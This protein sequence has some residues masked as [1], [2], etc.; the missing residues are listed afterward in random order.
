MP[1]LGET[2][3]D[4]ELG[5][6]GTGRLVWHACVD[7]GKERWV[8]YKAGKPGSLRCQSCGNYHAAKYCEDNALW[9]GGRYKDPE[10]YIQIRLRPDDP[11][12]SMVNRKRHSTPEHRLVMARHLDR[13]LERWEVVH[14]KNQIK[15][16]NR[17][18]NLELLP[19]Q[20]QHM[21]VMFMEK[22]IQ[23]L[24][25]RIIELETENAQ[26]RKGTTVA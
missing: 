13:P 26:L 3:L 7:C 10:G 19:H 4:R 17:L 20:A 18:E 14:H 16:D 15:D 23:S 25:Q 2:K 1:V 6:R 8:R 5:Y 22:E 24:Q 12:Y 11:F 9:R 21:G